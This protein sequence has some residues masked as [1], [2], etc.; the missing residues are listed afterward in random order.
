[1]FSNLPSRQ[2]G[3]CELSQCRRESACASCSSHRM[4]VCTYLCTERQACGAFSLSVRLLSRYTLQDTFSQPGQRT[5]Q[6]TRHADLSFAA[7]PQAAA[8]LLHLPS[9]SSKELAA[10]C[11]SSLT[12]MLYT[13]P[14]AGC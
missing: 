1:M 8:H 7:A 11:S 3:Q 14:A 4:L 2:Q 10:S 5:K 6:R 12:L 13:G 9:A